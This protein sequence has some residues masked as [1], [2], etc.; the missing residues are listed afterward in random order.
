MM[1][2]RGASPIRIKSWLRHRRASSSERY[3]EQARFKD[4][5]KK[6]EEIFGDIL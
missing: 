4:T 3:F 5:G 6:M 1:A 2:A